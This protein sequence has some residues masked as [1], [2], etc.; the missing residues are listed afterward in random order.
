MSNGTTPDEDGEEEWRTEAEVNVK[1]LRCSLCH[2][3]RFF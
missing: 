2:R 1:V 3:T